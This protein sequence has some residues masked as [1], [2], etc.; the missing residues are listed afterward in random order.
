MIVVATLKWKAD[1]IISSPYIL[2]YNV[3]NMSRHS[4]MDVFGGCT[5][6]ATILHFTDRET[7]GFSCQRA[8]GIKL[9]SLDLKLH[10]FDPGVHLSLRSSLYP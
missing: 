8:T 2:P 4:D 5:F 3:I 6:Q 1:H 10:L 7:R 9:Q